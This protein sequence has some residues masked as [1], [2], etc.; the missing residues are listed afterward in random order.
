MQHS[1]LKKFTYYKTT[2]GFPVLE[3]ANNGYLQVLHTLNILE[4]PILARNFI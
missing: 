1:F 2:L 3:L 4:Q